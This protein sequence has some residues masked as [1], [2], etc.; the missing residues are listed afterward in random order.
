M[1]QKKRLKGKKLLK[2]QGTLKGCDID[3]SGLKHFREQTW[4]HVVQESKNG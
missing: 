1:Q 2:L 4:Q 3:S